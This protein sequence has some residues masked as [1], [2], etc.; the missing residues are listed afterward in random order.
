MT[1]N[2]S[3]F[4]EAHVQNSVSD[5]LTECLSRYFM[6]TKTQASPITISKPAACTSP[7][8]GTPSI[9]MLRIRETPYERNTRTETTADVKVRLATKAPDIINIPLASNAPPGALV[10]LNKLM[11]LPSSMPFVAKKATGINR[12]APPV[13]V[14]I[15]PE[16]NNMVLSTFEFFM[17]MVN[18]PYSDDS[19]IKLTCQAAYITFRQDMASFK[20]NPL[21]VGAGHKT[22]QEIIFCY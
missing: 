21:F 16:T 20:I 7:S 10:S 13:T 12:I 2:R 14:A 3:Y 19:L 17:F 5:I 8:A 6:R 9:T 1:S 18:S 4:Q 11:L 22:K 15:R